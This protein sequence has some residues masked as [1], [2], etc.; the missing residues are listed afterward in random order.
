MSVDNH[1][2]LQAVGL[3]VD[4][5]TALNNRVRGN[6]G[7]VPFAEVLAMLEQDIQD[8]VVLASTKLDA[9]YSSAK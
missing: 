3:T 1:P 4:I 6:A 5:I 8:F 7:Q 2:N 9:T